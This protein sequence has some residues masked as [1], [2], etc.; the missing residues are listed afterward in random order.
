MRKI[1]SAVRRAG[2]IPVLEI[3]PEGV[4]GAPLVVYFHGYGG[5]K[6]DGI[7][8]GAMV[9]EEGLFFLAFDARGHGERA[10]AGEEPESPKNVYPAETGLDV[11]VHM[12]EIVAAAPAD[13]DRLLEAYRGD[14]RVRADRAGVIGDSMGGYAAFLLAAAE[15]RVRAAVPVIGLPAFVRRWEDLA[16]ET[17]T[18]D[19]WREAMQAAAPYTEEVTAFL[20]SIDPAPRLAGFAPK[21]LLILAGDQDTDQP[22]SYTLPVYRELTRR[23]ADCPE[24]MKLS[25]Y[26]GVPHAVT[27]T[28]REEACR[29]LA[30][31]L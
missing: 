2:N 16:L 25:V 12:L 3:Y 24:K 1:G 14:P 17:S 13:F 10:G 23:Y 29:W 22:K 4:V 19:R 20:R 30:R 31:H 9:A 28:M 11:W 21:P 18:Y 7:S 15:E 6:E 8:L 26:D 27:R 5:R